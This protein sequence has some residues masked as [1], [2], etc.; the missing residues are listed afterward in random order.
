MKINEEKAVSY[1]LTTAQIY[2]KI[3]QLLQSGSTITTLTTDGY[4]YD[5]ILEEETQTQKV[6][7]QEIMDL[8]IDSMLGQKVALKDIVTIEKASGFSAI[9]R[10]SQQRYITV[11]SKV[12]EGYNSGKVNNK[13]WEKVEQYEIPDGY[14][15]SMGGESEMRQN[16]FRDLFLMLGL[17]VILIYL[18]MVAQFQSLLSPL[19]VMF[20]IPLAFTGG[21]LALIITGKP[22]SV[23]A[24]L[25]LIVISGVVVNNGIV[26]VDYINILRKS[27]NEKVEAIIKAGNHRLRP[28]IM[29]ALTT[30]FAL[31]TMA[32]GVGMGTEMIQPMAITAIGGLIYAT[33]LTLIFIPVL[34]YIFHRQAHMT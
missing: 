34:Y 3:S 12:E 2:M 7:K 28:I 24:F 16:S 6:S 5:V 21:F 33:F 20:T 14:S 4:D 32:I 31:L 29:T 22:I 11:T 17:A 23:V 26:F 9:N 25:G 15:V 19:I 30:I 10:E 27:G 1:G 8:E 13:I 18:I